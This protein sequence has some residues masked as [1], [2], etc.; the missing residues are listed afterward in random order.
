MFIIFIQGVSF[1]EKRY[2]NEV[3]NI[4][5]PGLE[6]ALVF[7]C[8]LFLFLFFSGGDQCSPDCL[9]QK[10]LGW[11]LFKNEDKT[12]PGMVAYFFNPSTLETRQVNF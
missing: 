6:S 11:L 10:V 12:S 8:C 2:L 4:I 1:L 3:F 9:V 7:L 5:S